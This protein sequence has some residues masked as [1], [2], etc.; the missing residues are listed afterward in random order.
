L[1]EIPNRS[2]PSV[3]VKAP[4]RTCKMMAAR[5]RASFFSSTIGILLE[6]R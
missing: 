5:S 6:D 2:A 3:A 4:L 1:R